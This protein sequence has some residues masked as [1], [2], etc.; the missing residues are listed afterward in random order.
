MGFCNADGHPGADGELAVTPDGELGIGRRSGRIQMLAL[1]RPVI[2][3]MQKIVYDVLQSEGFKASEIPKKLMEPRQ[4][5][6][7]PLRWR[8][9]WGMQD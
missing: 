1:T 9:P 8:A 7:L 3:G 6:L 5:R 2:D 4:V